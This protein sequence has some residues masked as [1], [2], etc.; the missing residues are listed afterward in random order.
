MAT[1]HTVVKGDTLS[2]LAQKYG[3]TV[4][5]LVKLNN[6]SD[7]DYIVVGQVLKLS[8]SAATATKNVS[9]KATIK[10]FGL[11]SNTDR[12]V[13]ATWTWDRSS[14]D[15]YQVKWEY[16]T[17][18]GVW[19]VGNDS[20]VTVKQSVYNAPANATR[21]RFRVKPVSRTKKVG[22]KETVHW[23]A[24][25]STAVTYSFSSN[26][27][28]KPTS[29]PSVSIK[30]Y[31]L[32]VSLS[33]L[34]SDNEEIQFQIIR[35]NATVYKTVTVDVATSYVSYS[36][37][38]ASGSEY[39][40]RAR[41]INKN[42]TSEWTAYS[43][44]V[45][46][47]PSAPMM[48]FTCRASSA[49]SVYLEWT[50]STSAETY[51]VEY[52]TKKTY[53]DGSNA[54]T[55]TNPTEF[56]HYEITGLTSGEEYFFRVQA[57][58]KNGESGWS[59]IASTS[60]GKTP[61]A[62][63]TWSST[64][65]AMIGEPIYLYWVHNTKDGSS[66]TYGEVEIYV[67]DSKYTYT[68]TNTTNEDEK[69]K[70]SSYQI[71]SSYYSEGSTILWRVRTA[72]VTKSYGEWSV[73]RSIDVY[74][75]PTLSF[76]VTS[77]VVSFPFVIYALPSGNNQVPIGY[78]VTITANESY[79][80]VDNIGNAI[81]VSKGDAV[82]TRYL[83][84]NTSLRID[85]YPNDVNL[86]NNVSYTVTCTV[87]MDSGLTAEASDTFSV[88][89]SDVAYSPNAEIGIDEE[90]YSASIRPYL[91]DANNRT[92]SG[93]KLSVYRREYD[94]AFTEIA[95]NVVNGSSA[96]VTDPHPSLDYA[97]YRIVAIT[98]STGAVSYADI[99]GYPINCPAIIL[100]WDEEWHSF[101]SSNE[102]APSEPVW[103][104]SMVKLPYNVDLNDTYKPDVSH[105]EYIGREYPVSYFG[106][107]VGQSASWSSVI[108]KEDTE[109]L[110]ALRRL[111]RWRGN[112]YV[113]A[114]SG[115]GY[116]ATVIVNISEK[117]LETT[118]P[119]SLQIT[120]VEGGI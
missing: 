1:T 71:P 27:P 61:A 58:N 119:V 54:T 68:F 63:T 34:P 11:Q 48:I 59:P 118:I 55:K 110:Y 113:R 116:W 42:G 15:H 37:K 98:D 64:T 41:S 115:S 20:T 109:T 83:D 6:I 49:T 87:V 39:K 44:N 65:T 14:T 23:T 77:P 45:S 62:P 117:H 101:D 28:T 52:T 30:D 40:V 79:E 47:I 67:G 19:F 73:M 9:T 32:T 33:N 5:N 111:A 78:H 70:T 60:V 69:D 46:T 76:G 4:N 10:V 74:A 43:S 53:F 72:G 95:T 105:V 84:M 89:W 7:P 29:T 13:Y 103:S 94:G 96:Y 100:Q 75:P 8:G 82:Y 21:V 38:V 18:D 16:Y 112:V 97:R 12:T 25:W 88:A 31:T 50:P 106:T 102:D 85:L 99:P 24:E 3:T 80:G 17:S 2:E 26:P 108:D 90:T 51:V 66:Q 35:D 107:H 93:V 120:R 104:G 114:P 86:E 36:C 57:T 56:T 92:I 91:V 81:F 22:G